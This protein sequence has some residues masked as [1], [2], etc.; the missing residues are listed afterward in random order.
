MGSFP[1]PN[2]QTE[3]LLMNELNCSAETCEQPL[4]GQ[5]LRFLKISSIM[6]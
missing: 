3:F 2:L 1:A 6:L 4:T 5:Y